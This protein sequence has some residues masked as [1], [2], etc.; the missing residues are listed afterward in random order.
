ME[1]V[2][3]SGLGGL[4]Q[5]LAA[6]LESAGSAFLVYE[7]EGFENKDLEKYNPQTLILE[8]LGSFIDQLKKIGIKQICFSGSIT[9]PNLKLSLVDELTLPLVPVIVEALK[10]GDDQALRLVLSIFEDSGF[11]ILGAH[12]ICPELLI[13]AGIHSEIQPEPSDYKDAQKAEELMIGLSP[14]DIGQS[15]IVSSG[16]VLGIETSSGTDMMLESIGF[17]KSLKVVEKSKFLCD[18]DQKIIKNGLLYKAAKI[19]QD[20]RVDM[21]VIG[22]KT[23]C[24]ANKVGIKGVVIKFGNVLVLNYEECLRLSNSFGLFFLVEK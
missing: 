17:I 15:C 19:G 14:F 18:E 8:H 12:E 3:V 10:H 5:S 6:N 22:P 23:F 2:L 13:S 4:P 24:L 21:P 9:R 7:I 1:L 20:L 16:Q 11:K